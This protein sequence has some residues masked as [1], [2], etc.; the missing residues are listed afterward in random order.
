MRGGRGMKRYVVDGVMTWRARVE[1]EV[2][3]ENAEEAARIADMTDLIAEAAL[4]AFRTGTIDDEDVDIWDV[5]PVPE[6]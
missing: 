4:E 6:G 2:E 3:A 5:R 1:V